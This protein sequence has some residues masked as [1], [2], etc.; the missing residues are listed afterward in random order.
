MGILA[1]GILKMGGGYLSPLLP[2]S[3]SIFEAQGSFCGCRPSVLHTRRIAFLFPEAGRNSG[4]Q[5]T[6]LASACSLKFKASG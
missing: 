3:R 2:G 5:E 1:M 4:L 6:L